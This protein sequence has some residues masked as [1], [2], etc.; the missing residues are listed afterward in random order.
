MIIDR[1][2]AKFPHLQCHIVHLSSAAALPLIRKY[3]LEQEE[4]H[5]TV[6]TCF[7]YLCLNA[8]DIPDGKPEFKCCPP[9]RDDANRDALWKGLEEGLI[10]FVV[11][12][13]SPCTSDLKYPAG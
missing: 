12:D 2:L 11:S 6:E 7:H 4:C 1:F 8:A 10:D 13:H 9:I 5:L 3:V